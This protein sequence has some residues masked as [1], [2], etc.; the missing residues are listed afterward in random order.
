MQHRPG[1]W[2]EGWMKHCQKYNCSPVFWLAVSFMA[3]YK[4]MITIKS[5]NYL[6]GFSLLYILSSVLVFSSKP[7]NQPWQAQTSK[8]KSCPLQPYRHPPVYQLVLPTWLSTIF[9][10]LCY[11][12]N[13]LLISF[14]DDAVVC[15]LVTLNSPQ[16]QPVKS[17]S[18]CNL[19]LRY[20]YLLLSTTY[21]RTAEKKTLEFGRKPCQA[22]KLALIAH[23]AKKK[24]PM[25]MRVALWSTLR[26]GD[27]ELTFFRLQN[28]LR[29]NMVNLFNVCNTLEFLVCLT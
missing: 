22:L 3:W 12:K 18:G 4:D 6:F 29:V 13:V 21:S 19:H 14:R 7:D 28:Q 1:V 8:N 16:V 11:G 15:F 25:H 27:D 23:L 9:W 24:E 17:I 2:W 5:V 20:W 26:T 10:R